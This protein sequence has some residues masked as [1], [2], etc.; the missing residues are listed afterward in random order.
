MLELD[1]ASL[2]MNRDLACNCLYAHRYDD[3]IT[4][5]KA[6][7]E[8]DPANF[9]EKKIIA[10]AYAFKGSKDGIQLLRRPP[11]RGE[12]EPVGESSRV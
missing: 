5:G 2:I 10:F 7:L 12:R 4:Q 8:M 11:R 1:P 3:A 6:T 9:D